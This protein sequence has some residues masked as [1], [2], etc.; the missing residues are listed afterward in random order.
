M[1]RLLM[2]VYL[3][4]MLMS[5]LNISQMES[6]EDQPAVTASNYFAI[7]VIIVSFVVPLALV[8]LACFRFKDWDEA[9]EEKPFKSRFSAF[10]DG[11]RR[12]KD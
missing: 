5:L 12:K 8:V 7:T 10:F 2:E 6:P 3:D 1:I 4:F 11:M 9:T